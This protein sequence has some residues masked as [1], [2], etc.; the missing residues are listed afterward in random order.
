M[1]T[2]F[3]S[4]R[5]RLWVEIDA[6]LNPVLEIPVTIGPVGIDEYE[7]PHGAT[8]EIHDTATFLL[9]HL[10]VEAGINACHE[11]FLRDANTH[12]VLH[13]KTNASHHFLL[14][15]P[16][17]FRAEHMTNPVCEMF[18]VWH[19]WCQSVCERMPPTQAG[20]S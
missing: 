20:V 15:G 13:E 11:R 2:L 6:E 1:Q 16:N 17:M 8:R 7:S 14:F 5:L 4:A 3:L 18:I 19:W 12:L 10:I 9:Q